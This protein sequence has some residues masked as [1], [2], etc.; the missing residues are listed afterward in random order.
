MQD[1]HETGKN[2][3]G[4][5]RLGASAHVECREPEPGTDPGVSQVEPR[6]RVCGVRTERE[7]PLGGGRAEGAGLRQVEQGG[8]RCSASLRAPVV[9]KN[10]VRPVRPGDADGIPRCNIVTSVAITCRKSLI[11]WW[12]KGSMSFCGPQVV[13]TPGA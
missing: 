9:R 6:D 5:A 4:V 13:S 1:E 2:G 7:I 11:Q 12:L 8:A 3:V 10:L